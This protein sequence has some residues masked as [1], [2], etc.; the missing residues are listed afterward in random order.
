MKLNLLKKLG[1][2]GAIAC[3]MNY[4]SYDMG[5]ELK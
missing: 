3:M 4:H 1:I 5:N 2:V